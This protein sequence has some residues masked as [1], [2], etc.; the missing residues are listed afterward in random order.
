MILL[1]FFIGLL[2]SVHC[3]G[4]CGPLM[5]AVLDQQGTF[6]STASQQLLYQFGRIV[7]YSLL[8]LVLGLLGAG[9]I[10]SGWQQHLSIL[11]G[12]LLL[13]LGVYHIIGRQIPI[14]ARQQQ[15]L[16]APILQKMGYW[17]RRP[18]G[19]FMVG[20][21]NG[22]LPCGMVYLALASALNTG[23]PLR[24]GLFMLW[25][26]LGTL[27]L[28]LGASIIGV[29]IKGKL[30]IKLAHWLPLLLIVFGIWFILRG[31]NLAIPYLSPAL[32]NPAAIDVLCK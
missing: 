11:T 9:G 6:W 8:G 5:F 32:D 22:L 10:I 29:A 3:V 24:G 21:L 1:A 2:G 12:C 13:L 4:M 30:K 23:T 31:S 19:H 16:I 18:G 25:F 28:M 15:M 7:T 27:P 17:L 26:G 14:I 20:L